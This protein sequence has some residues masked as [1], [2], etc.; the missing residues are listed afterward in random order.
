M[1]DDRSPRLLWTD[2]G[3]PR[4]G[5]F[6][7]VYFSREDGLA[8][9]RAV[10]L[11]GCGLP[12]IWRERRRFTV[13]ELGFGTG[14]NI[15]ALLDLWRQE[16]PQGG[17]LHIFSVEGFPLSRDE[18]ARALA[19][20]P[21]IADA[22]QAL[23]AAWPRATPGL[24]RLDLPAF[25]AVLD[26]YVGPVETALAQWAGQ[27]DAWFLDGFAPSTNPDMWSDTVMD[28][29]AAR[30]APGARI[31]T[32]TVAGQVR[33]GLA[34][35]GFRVEK[36]PGH[37]R[38]RERLEAWRED[39]D[40]ERAP[41]SVAIIGA[42]IAGAAL[43][44][45]FGA[46]GL[47]PTVVEADRPGAGASGFDASLVT[48][49]LDAGDREIAALYATALE[50][51][52]A[53]YA[54]TPGAVLAG[55]VLQLE[56]MPRDVK[57]HLKIAAQDVWSDGGMTVL[58]A[59]A[60]AGH[61]AEPCETGGLL[62]R[63]A[64]AIRPQAVLDDWLS[65]V[66][67]KSATVVDLQ[68]GEDGWRLIDGSGGT[69]LKADV[70]VLAAGWG[71]AALRT[72]MPLAPVAGQADVAAGVDSPPVAWGGYAVPTGSGL[73]FGATHDRG[74]TTP[75][76]SGDATARNRATLAGRLPE[77]GRRVDAS[78]QTRSRVAV[79]ATTPDRLPVAGPLGDGLFILGG[80]GSRGFCVAPL[81]AEHI[82]ALACAAP[83]PLTRDLAAR[84]APQRFISREG[85]AQP[86]G[87][88]DADL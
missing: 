38:K 5:R 82:V 85:L 52:G 57:R 29:I 32:F 35:R 24:H 19:A 50:R 33:R 62:M 23:L 59:D 73:L 44:R 69:I 17:R 48:P 16:R 2:D 87:T 6:D 42:G 80:L 72:S 43:A 41:P 1:T 40:V 27:A 7:D 88:S 4:S 66:D 76:P 60:C 8:E 34:A 45:A 21:E 9:S 15:A 51:A 10:F 20:W 84:I 63:D 18:A 13:A 14:L 83:S 81:L 70:V 36:R 22:A 78:G 79:R 68:P 53:L 71:N 30:S 75:T 46:L 37:G 58:D 49:R 12:D 74:V 86:D 11:S 47:H 3:A 56:Q 54:A 31:A 26:L 39:V 67:V 55:G 64:L 25:D 77:L 65:A 28:L 61:L